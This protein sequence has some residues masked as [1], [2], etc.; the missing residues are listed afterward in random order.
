MR[1]TLFAIPVLL[2]ILT[3]CSGS[4]TS[5]SQQNKNPLVASRFG[6]ELADTMANLIIT[7]DP[8]ID[9]PAMRTVIEREIERGKD[10]AADAREIQNDGWMGAIITV[11]TE[12]F[13]YALYVDTTLYLSSDFA[14]KPGPAPHVYLTTVVDPRDVAFPDDTAIDL[15]PLQ[16]VYGA[17][18]Y[19]VP[20]QKEPSKLRTFVLY[21]ETLHSISGF[22]QLSR[23]Y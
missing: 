16:T 22:A 12:T 3:A 19:K 14:T 17:Q 4:T 2:L 1:P 5:I 23:T 11:K 21:D 7:H 8:I 18:Q 13:G 15:G 10:I 9:D 6:D 20:K